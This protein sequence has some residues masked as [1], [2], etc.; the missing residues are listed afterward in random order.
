MQWCGWGG[1]GCGRLGERPGGSCIQRKTTQHYTTQ[2]NATRTTTYRS[3]TAYTRCI[4]NNTS[5]YTRQKRNATTKDRKLDHPVAAL[6]NFSSAIRSLSY[7]DTSSQAFTAS[8]SYDELGEPGNRKGWL[9]EISSMKAPFSP[10]PLSKSTRS[11]KRKVTRRRG[12]FVRSRWTGIS[13]T[14][15]QSCWLIRPAG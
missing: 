11:E 4:F 7:P 12:S 13:R 2:H 1:C 9:H 14:K 10:N 6:R 3:K 5:C 15:H 8:L